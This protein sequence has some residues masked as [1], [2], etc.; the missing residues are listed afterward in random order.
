MT[1]KLYG[2]NG[3][4]AFINLSDKSVDIKDLPPQLAKEYLGG[5]GISAKITYD[6]LSDDDF[7]LL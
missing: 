1:E 2:Y 3:K 5:T 7:A 4:I 6:L